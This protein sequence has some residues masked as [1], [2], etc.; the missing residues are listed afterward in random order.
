MARR[1]MHPAAALLLRLYRDPA[2]AAN[3]SP[4]DWALLFGAMRRARCTGLVGTRLGLAGVLGALP[5][6]V[7]GQFEVARIVAAERG[8][9]LDWELA[10]VARALAEFGSPVIALKGAAYRLQ[11]LPLALGRLPGDLD[12][13]VARHDLARAESLLRRAGWAPLPLTAHD[14]R[15][16]R[17]WSHEIV[18]LRHP[19]RGIELDL[20]HAI[21]PGLTGLMVDTVALQ[22]KAVPA[23]RFQVLSPA[24]Q[25]IHCALHTFKDSDLAGRLREVM[26]FD[27]LVR[28]FGHSDPAGF[29]QALWQRADQ[30]GAVDALALAVRTARRWLGTPVAAQAADASAGDVPC[31]SRSASRVIDRLLDLAMLPGA[32]HRPDVV[33]RLARGLL[34]IRYHRLRMP[35]GLLVRHLAYKQWLAVRGALAMLKH[36]PLMSRQQGGP[37]LEP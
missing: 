14:E 31:T 27:L 10:E 22:G 15:Y 21:T 16:Y 28:A 26:D 7:Q 2:L 30:L 37:P 8:H 5:D 11:R 12:L 34:L 29:S 4:G 17:E 18:P 32:L 6:V 25:V 23:G 33:A 19:A 3:C 24:D 9:L 36:R 1:L 20:H 35:L 13:L